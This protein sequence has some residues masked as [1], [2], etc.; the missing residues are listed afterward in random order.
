MSLKEKL[1]VFFIK[2]EL[3][4]KENQSMLVKVVGLW[5][6]AQGYKSQW[7]AALSVLT[8]VGNILGFISGDQAKE[9]LAIFGSTY[10]LTMADKISRLI[11][12]IKEIQPIIA[13]TANINA[14]QVENVSVSVPEAK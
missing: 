4:K 8:I 10:A 7:M 14:T 12:V 1:I 5:G 2:K 9:L 6:K 11:S 3:K 13:N